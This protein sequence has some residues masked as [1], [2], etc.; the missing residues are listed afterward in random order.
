[1]RHPDLEASIRLIEGAANVIA[2][3]PADALAQLGD[4]VLASSADARLWRTMARVQLGDLDGARQ[5]ALGSELLAANYPG[6]IRTRYLLAG[7]R[8]AVG[9]ED[10]TLATRLLRQIDLRHEPDQIA[11]FELLSGMLDEL[12]DGRRKR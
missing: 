8:A 10:V 4:G 11:E 2:R 6:W 3:R 1:M 9:E 12:N 7:I 5:E